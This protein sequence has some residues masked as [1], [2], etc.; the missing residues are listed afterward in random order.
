MKY[1]NK[2]GTSLKD[3]EC[4]FS[5][6]GAVHNTKESDSLPI[7]DDDYSDPAK[8]TIENIE[9]RV[10][11]YYNDTYLSAERSGKYVVLHHETTVSGDVCNVVVR[12]QDNDNSNAYTSVADISV[13]MLTGDCSVHNKVINRKER[14]TTAHKFI[15]LIAVLVLLNIVFVPFLSDEDGLIVEDGGR[16]H[17]HSFADMTERLSDDYS[18]D[19]EIPIDGLYYI[20]GSICTLFIFFSALGKISVYC[21]VG[22]AG[23][24]IL[25]LYLFY[26]IYLGTTRWYIGLQDAHL[27]FGFYISCIGFLSMF[28]ASI[29]KK[30]E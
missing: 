5:E 2:C 4:H 19:D 10:A 1:C 24:I 3:D 15:C 30:Q 17:A 6:C 22:S 14:R 8:N 23:G 9:K 29:Y 11:K 7:I 12:Y 20:G 25:S 18:S 16:V 13:N 21:T 27:T 26:Q 28:I